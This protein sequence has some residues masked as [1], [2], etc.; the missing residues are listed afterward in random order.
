MPNNTPHGDT[1]A[2]IPQSKDAKCPGRPARLDER[3]EDGG[4][5]KATYSGSSQNDTHRKAAMPVE[6]NGA[7]GHDGKV[8]HRRADAVQDCLCKVQLPYLPKSK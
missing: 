6:P 2:E 5:D 4:Y 1:D 3:V 7:Y 8:K